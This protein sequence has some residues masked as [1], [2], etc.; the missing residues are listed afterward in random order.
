MGNT[1]A[2]P[3]NPQSWNMYSYVLNNPLK[4]TDPTG[5]YCDYSDHNDPASTFDDSQ[6]DYHTNQKEC[7]GGSGQWVADA[8]THGGFD[9]YGRPEFAVSSNTQTSGYPQP[10]ADD[11]LGDLLLSTTPGLVDNIGNAILF[12]V[13]PSS[14]GGNKLSMTRPPSQIL[15]S[16]TYCGPGGAGSQTGSL[17]GPCAVHD[18]CYAGVAG[19]GISAANNRPGGPQMTSAQIGGEKACNQALYDAARTHPDVPGSAAVQWW[20][21][22]GSSNFPRIG[23]ILHPGA[24]AVPW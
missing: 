5:M 11:A 24:E 23:Y 19:G 15:F 4:F 13:L 14:L 2:D 9:D 20:L 21:V 3:A 10:T 7:E 16:T 1:A 12:A 17:N 22:N 8:Y 6:F 18:A